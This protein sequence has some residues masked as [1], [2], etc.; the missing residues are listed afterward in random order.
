VCFFYK[1]EK[2]IISQ[3]STLGGE[4]TGQEKNKEKKSVMLMRRKKIISYPLTW[5]YTKK[6]PSLHLKMDIIVQRIQN[7]LGETPNPQLTQLKFGTTVII[8]PCNCMV[9][10]V[11]IRP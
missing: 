5:F 8:K 9:M 11:S 2:L 1:N 3:S 4:E 10:K 6:M 7:F